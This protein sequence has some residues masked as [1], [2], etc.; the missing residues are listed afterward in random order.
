MENNYINPVN[1]VKKKA[2]VLLNKFKYKEEIINFYC[3]R[4]ILFH[5]IFRFLLY[6]RNGYD[7]TFFCV[8]Q[9]PKK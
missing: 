3:V 7:S 1:Q 4:S 5:I 2:S 8:L 6:K 9:E